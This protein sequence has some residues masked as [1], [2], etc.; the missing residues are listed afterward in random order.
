MAQ[1]VQVLLVD[2]IDGGTAD[3][4]VTFGLDGVTYEIDLNDKNSDALR[5]ALSPFL[6]NA[7]RARSGAA[8]RGGRSA[9]R[10]TDKDRNANIRTWAVEN[11]V[12]LP[13][14]GRVAGTVQQA[15]DAQDVAALFSAV[16]LEMDEPK[17]RRGRSRSAEFSAAVA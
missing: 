12:E 8:G 17:P 9:T 1:K 4:T 14:R 6:E 10:A 5:K 16:G 15:Y 2:D 11:G 3:E 7:R 13:S